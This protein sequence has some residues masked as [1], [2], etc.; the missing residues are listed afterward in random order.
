MNNPWTELAMPKESACGKLVSSEHSLTIFWAKDSIGHYLIV[1]E[2]NCLP[3]PKNELLELSG[4]QMFSGLNGSKSTLVISLN[5]SADW[6][7]FYLVCD[8]LIKTTNGLTDDQAWPAIKRRLNKWR[9]FLSLG[10]LNIL[11]EEKIKGLIGE[12]YFFKEHVIKHLNISTA[13]RCWEGPNGAAQDFMF[14]KCAVE[15]KC[16]SGSTFSHVTISSVEQLTCPVAQL[17]L[18]VITI[19]SG[20]PDGKD[21]IT[22]PEIIREIEAIITNKG[23]VGDLESF[24]DLLISVGYQESP[25][26]DR[27]IYSVV[28]SRMFKVGNDFPRIRPENVPPAIDK[29]SYRIDLEQC[30]EFQVEINDWRRLND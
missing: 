19:V 6:Q 10:R 26:Y 22:L 25:E 20:K 12:L 1:F 8:D 21:I 28:D 3:I 23:Q 17:F 13:L 27:F 24:R 29:L 9:D 18:F 5:N 7:L 16:Q 30:R 15:V 14:S 11:S 2:L 4:L